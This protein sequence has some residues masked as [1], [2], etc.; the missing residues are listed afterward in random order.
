VYGITS[1]TKLL[2]QIFF[3][4][5]NFF[6]YHFSVAKELFF[7]FSDVKFKHVSNKKEYFFYFVTLGKAITNS[8]T[9]IKK[10]YLQYQEINES[11]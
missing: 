5:N 8:Y 11:F 7:D 6:F 4:D 9:N 2:E 10:N 3:I 1:K